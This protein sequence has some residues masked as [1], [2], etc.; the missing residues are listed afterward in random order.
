M[1]QLLVFSISIILS[2]PC[3]AQS[4]LVYT[5][6][7][8]IV[9]K[10]K[11]KTAQIKPGDQLTDKTVL[12]VSADGRLTVIDEKNES[13]Y[14]VKEGIGTLSAL[15]AAQQS[16]SRPV[17][18]SFLAF[19][20]EKVSTKN[21]PKDVNYMQ[22]AGVTYRGLGKDLI[23]L[24]AGKPGSLLNPLRESFAIAGEALA[25]SDADGLLRVSDRLDSLGLV[26]YAFQ[27]V[28][29]YEPRSFNGYFIFDPLCLMDLAAN[30]DGSRPF[31][32]QMADLPVPMAPSTDNKLSGGNILCNYYVL[33]PGQTL[34]L[35][36][37]CSGYCEIAALSLS[38]N[39]TASFDGSDAYYCTFPEETTARII[40]TNH[41]EKTEA[42]LFAV[43]AE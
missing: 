23:P 1:K 27:T 24:Q 5:V 16:K 41:S 40:L 13:L 10:D 43:N 19:V 35:A 12:T 39:V 26:R 25:E 22:A 2:L 9:S 21:N 20:K 15:I 6:K 34:E 30:L 33:Q 14:T 17:T 8:D 29:G 36:V 38:G 28:T 18:P 3:V 4:Y 11:A 42:V 37:V 31:A 7:G 32:D